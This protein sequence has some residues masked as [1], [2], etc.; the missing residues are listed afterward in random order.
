MPSIW[1]PVLHRTKASRVFEPFNVDWYLDH[2]NALLKTLVLMK[3][4]L[5]VHTFTMMGRGLTSKVSHMRVIRKIWLHK[6]RITFNSFEITLE[7][8]E[9]FTLNLTWVCYMV[10]NY[11]IQP[12]FDLAHCAKC[13]LEPGCS[14]VDFGE[15][16]MMNG[17]KTWAPCMC[18]SGGHQTH[19]ITRISFDVDLHT[20]TISVIQV[21]TLV[22]QP[23]VLRWES[24][25]PHH[26]GQKNNLAVHQKRQN[27]TI[28]YLR[29]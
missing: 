8:V 2:H 23:I 21:Y 13:D 12:S 5:L 14:A 25:S 4:I 10:C 20:P 1:W 7:I 22:K 15:T 17:S 27:S 29:L 11:P 16:I 9:Y 18:C 6:P 19:D 3:V 26:R 24:T 28:R